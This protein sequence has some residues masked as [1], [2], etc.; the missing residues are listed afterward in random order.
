MFPNTYCR[1]MCVVASLNHLGGGG[2]SPRGFQCSVWV[3]VRK[4]S[5]GVTMNALFC[6]HLSVGRIYT[7]NTPTTQ[8]SIIIIHIHISTH[9]LHHEHSLMGKKQ[10]L[11]LPQTTITKLMEH[12]AAFPELDTCRDME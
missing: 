10:M 4:L 7:N 8:R 9:S 6:L 2:D 12:M 1:G 3:G 5:D 11:H